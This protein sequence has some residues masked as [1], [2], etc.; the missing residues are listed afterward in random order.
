LA[1]ESPNAVYTTISPTYKN[2]AEITGVGGQ[3]RLAP[4]A[5]AHNM[6]P[7]PTLNRHLTIDVDNNS[8][9]PFKSPYVTNT[10]K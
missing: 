1:P 3:R 8:A 6:S 2:S 9:P 10:N 4:N 5:L 7:N